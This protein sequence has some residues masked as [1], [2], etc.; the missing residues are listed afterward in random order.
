VVVLALTA[1][2]VSLAA[3]TIQQS[4]TT[5]NPLGASPSA[6]ASGRRL[7]D[8]ACVACHGAGGQGDRGPALTSGVFARGNDDGDLFR[9]IRDGVPGSQMPPHRG[10]TDDETWQMVSYIRSLSV[11]TSAGD[12][13]SSPSRVGDVRNGETLFFGRA[14]CATCHQVNG[15]GGT[16][17]PDLSLAGR[18]NAVTIR[19]KILDPSLPTSPP[20]RGTGPGPIRPQVVVARTKDGREIRGVRRNE[21]TFSVQV[22]DASGALHLLDKLQLASFRVENT[23]LMPPDYQQKLTERELGDL[24]AYLSARRERTL[25]VSAADPA[26][27]G[28][29]GLTFDRL[30]QS[31]AEPHN[32]LMY[33]GNYQSTHYS[34]LSQITTSNAASLQ[35]AW[36]F[37]MPGDSV[38]EATPIVVDG[39]MYTTQPGVVVA[40]DA[41]TGRQLWRYARPQKVRNPF[42]INP[43]NRGVA[44]LGQ[45]LY[46]VTLDAALVALDARTGLPL[47]EVQVA[48]SMLGYSLTSAPLIVKDKLLVGITGGEFG[49]RG[50]LDA[51]DAT[52]G[53]RLWRWYAVPGPGE[54]GNDTW[55]GGSWQRGGSPM[56]LTGSY[57]P[58][59]NLAY[60]AVGNPGPQIDRTAR[61]EL[62]N[63][64]SDSVVAINPDT[65]QRVWHY[66]FTPNDGHDW[67]S[68]QDMILVDRVWHG[69]MRKLLLHADRNGHFYVLDRTTGEF[70]SGT[71]FVYQNW[72]AGFDAKG[73]P[74]QVPGSNSSRAG[75]FFVYPTVGGATN[76]QAPSYSS[77]TGWLYLAYSENGQQYVSTD[78]VYE[79]GRQYIGRTTSGATVGPKTSEPSP[80]AGI[81]ALDPET[82]KTMW[83][84]KIFQGSN[85]NGVLATGGGVVF[86]AIRDGN[87]VALD[88]KTGRH[89]WHVQTGGNLAASPMSYAIDGRQYVAIAA[90]N[91]VFAFALPASR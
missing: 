60:W 62:D 70:L 3:R 22:V 45:R 13:T 89:L 52:T 67:D 72:N 47:W 15:R 8:Q 49:A 36:T 16:V 55:L 40:L 24:V 68:C 63:L 77:Q 59:S 78:V 66:Q 29:H 20:G 42:E 28:T 46:F 48:D 5:R 51:Y 31:A 38:L 9:V 35:T 90:G 32:W 71:P 87:V 86:G 10:L 69:R 50:F 64:F 56:W 27:A 21:D 73:R 7:Y 23:S 37:P 41:R 84:F 88:A 54:F 12:P 79:A 18:L 14:A 81:K 43:Y 82:G 26:G 25:D 53:R 6:V 19:Q 1:L 44:I 83:D 85:T 74:N 2:S 91:S 17:G 57:D 65:G 76:F 75:S 61:G 30:V 58:E 4:D 39:V 34:A 11:S 80:S 33:W